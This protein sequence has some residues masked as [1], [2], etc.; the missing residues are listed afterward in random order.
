MTKFLFCC[1]MFVMVSVALSNKGPDCLEMTDLSQ[2]WVKVC[3]ECFTF[4]VLIQNYGL[5]NNKT[6]F[7]SFFFSNSS[8]QLAQNCR[9]CICWQRPRSAETPSDLL[10]PAST[11]A[12]CSILLFHRAAFQLVELRLLQKQNTTTSLCFTDS[13]RLR[14]GMFLFGPLPTVLTLH[15]EV[16]S[17]LNHFCSHS[18]HV[19]LSVSLPLRNIGAELWRPTSS[20]IKRVVWIGLNPLQS[21][22][23][24][25][26]LNPA[27]TRSLKAAREVFKRRESTFRS[28][29]ALSSG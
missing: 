8:W 6:T 10:T 11:S 4:R 12:K 25:P 26:S 28:D 14:A 2:N 5:I 17:F 21:K 9:K 1:V 27:T 20:E 7:F 3:Q 23:F 16:K 15:K 18:F 22:A 19:S 13:P 24:A 29:A